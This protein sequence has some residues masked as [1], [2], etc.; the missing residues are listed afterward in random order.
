MDP[1]AD[2]V[3]FNLLCSISCTFV[4]SVVYRHDQ[5]ICTAQ[6]SVEDIS[7]SSFPT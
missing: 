6:Y 7:T 5:R 2:G 4:A 1:L 3:I